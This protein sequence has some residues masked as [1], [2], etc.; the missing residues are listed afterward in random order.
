MLGICALG[1]L[2]FAY[3][4]TLISM[5]ELNLIGIGGQL[6]A[7]NLWPEILAWSLSFSFVLT[8][9]FLIS[10]AMVKP[11]VANR[12]KP[13]RLFLTAGWLVSFPL[14]EWLGNDSDRIYIWTALVL[15]VS[16]VALV[17][18]GCEREGVSRLMRQ[19]IPSSSIKRLAAFFF[20]SGCANGI[21]WSSLILSSSLAAC[22]IHYGS[23]VDEDYWIMVAIALYTFA[24]VNTSVFV[25]NKWFATKV[26]KG[27]T[28][29]ITL[30]ILTALTTIPWI[31]T[32][33][34]FPSSW[35]NM[36]VVGMF[37]ILNPFVLN[38]PNAP[39]IWNLAAVSLWCLSIAAIQVRWFF[40]QY[41]FFRPASS[42]AQQPLESPAT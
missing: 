27:Y 9:L 6:L 3:F 25:R 24:Y 23:S 15:M 22:I 12:A 31:L 1:C 16:M 28:W 2:I 20:Y 39:L 18:A 14:T 19:T 40:A 29:L 42:A 4:A 10:V 26:K 7:G 41:R 38:A 17:V 32:L 21:A 11:R 37:H 36:S 33:L 13:V 34:F 5:S 30:F 8:A 35:N